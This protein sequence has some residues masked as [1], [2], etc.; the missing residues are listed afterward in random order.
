MSRELL[1]L[2]SLA[3]VLTLYVCPASSRFAGIRS[4]IGS[5]CGTSTAKLIVFA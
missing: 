3:W 5:A 4:V 1:P 2:G